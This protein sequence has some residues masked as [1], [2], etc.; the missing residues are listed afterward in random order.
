ML[1]ILKP[2][3]QRQSSRP[4]GRKEKSR[5]GESALIYRAG[6]DRRR[7][8]SIGRIGFSQQR[9]IAISPG[10]RRMDETQAAPVEACDRVNA[11]H[12]V[13]S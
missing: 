10:P 12:E 7:F 3:K 2:S 13:W 6:N 11:P 5:P 1:P 9:A 8:A 4:P